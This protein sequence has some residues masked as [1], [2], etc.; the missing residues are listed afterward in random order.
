MEPRILLAADP[1]TIAAPTDEALDLTLRVFDGTGGI[2]RV[3]VVDHVT[4]AVEARR[5]DETS[6]ITVAGSSANDRLRL[7]LALGYLDALPITFAGGDGTD[8][9]IG[10]GLDATW[11]I[12]AFGAGR[13]GS[14]AFTGIENLT[15]AAGN[16]D[17][18]VFLQHGGLARSRRRRRRRLRPRRPG[19]LVPGRALRRDR[20]PVRLDRSRR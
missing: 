9:L 14:T 1:L 16:D 11:T 10:P 12:D 20:A 5:L 15:G 6:E 4:G 8:E 3:E 2:P 7:D 17:S 19:R 13:V 18:F